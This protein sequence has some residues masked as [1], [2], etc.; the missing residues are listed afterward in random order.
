[1]DNI[2]YYDDDTLYNWLQEILSDETDRIILPNIPFNY[3][4]L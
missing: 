4:E 2:L 3:Y 1:M